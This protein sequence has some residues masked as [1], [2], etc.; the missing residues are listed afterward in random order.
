MS[1]EHNDTTAHR[2]LKNDKPF[3]K[4]VLTGGPCGGKTTALARVSSYLRERGFEVFTAPE[5]FTLLGSNG[6]SLDYFAT[7]GMDIVFQGTLLDMQRSVEDGMET[8]LKARGL[9]S[10]ILCDRGIMDGAAYMSSESWEHI[11]KSRGL[12][13]T[14]AREGRYNA[15][16]HMVTAAEGAEQ[17]YSL[18]NNAVRSESPEMAREVDNKT[19]NVWNGHPKHYVLDNST[20][21]EGKLQRLVETVAGL[22]GLPTNLSRTTS[23]FLL[24]DRPNLDAFPDDIDYHIFDVEKVYL[25][26]QALEGSSSQFKEEYAF[27]RKRTAYSKSGKPSG[28]AYGI[29]TVQI[30]E[31][32]RTIETKRI[33]TAREYTASL[34]TRD[35][36]R[37]IIRQQRI[38]FL[39]RLQSFVLHIYNEPVTE[40]CILHAQVETPKGKESHVDLPP[41]LNVERQLQDTP[42]DLDKYG[43]FSISLMNK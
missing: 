23:K 19:R 27:V 26:N 34:N 28:S 4:I 35:L 37:N 36:T 20:D 16:F 30:T 38:S 11:L 12:D 41:F 33:I 8:V 1:D 9:P 32:G 14:D 3:F 17:Y 25:V 5:V 21:F 2:N 24:R 43:A 7:D 29:T 39:Y 6:F 22:V 13:I 31:E 10:V 40:L 15:V 18:D 42:E